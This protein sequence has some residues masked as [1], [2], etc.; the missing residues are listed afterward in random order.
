MPAQN[1]N[2]KPAAN[3]PSTARAVKNIWRKSGTSLS[4]KRWAREN[5]AQTAEWLHNKKAN[6][7]KPAQGIG[8]TNRI[9]KGKK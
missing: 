9:S 1:A 6:T 8:R 7:S 4:L 2:K 5:T 3:L